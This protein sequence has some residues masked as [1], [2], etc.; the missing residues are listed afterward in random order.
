M[1]VW[2]RIVSFGG[3][4]YAVICVGWA[5]VVARVECGPCVCMLVRSGRRCSDGG[6]CGRVSP[7]C[8]ALACALLLCVAIAVFIL[9]SVLSVVRA[10]CPSLDIRK[11]GKK[12]GM[13][14]GWRVKNC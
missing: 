5:S 4:C 9:S 1:G 2:L 14:N 6:A 3:Y 12:R 10:V 11:V 13:R 7:C 8:L